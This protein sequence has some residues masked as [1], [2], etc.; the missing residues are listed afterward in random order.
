[1]ANGIGPTRPGER[2]D[3][4]TGQ[5]VNVPVGG[6]GAAPTGDTLADALADLGLDTS[7]LRSAPVSDELPVF[8][9]QTRRKGSASA[10]KPTYQ[11]KVMPLSEAYGEFYGFDAKTLRDFQEQA[12]NAGYYGNVDRGE[13]RW[14][15]HDEDTLSIWQ[16]M[17][18]RSAGF[19]A[20]GK[21][22]SP[23]EA[24]R[25]STASAPTGPEEPSRDPLTT[26]ISS[27]DDLR[28]IF[29]AG[30][31]TVQGRKI[32][33]A[34]VDKW[35]ARYQAGEAAEQQAAYSMTTTGGTITQQA[36]PK[37]QAEVEAR[38]ADPLHADARVVV[39]K[40]AMLKDMLGPGGVMQASEA[41]E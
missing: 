12:Y 3:P 24:L 32:D 4:I 31:R 19:Y 29:E 1:M 33:P 11:Q 23:F 17:V 13:I 18:Q 34:Q 2:I 26:V 20:Q 10:D 40:F 16:A 8:M 37:V 41:E 14:G 9:G 28:K 36:S 6:A 5:G 27:P 21:K 35:I 7:S 25:R 30:V 15:D 38:E 22:V 39:K